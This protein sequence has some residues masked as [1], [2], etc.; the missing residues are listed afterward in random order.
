MHWRR[1]LCQLSCFYVVHQI[2][3]CMWVSARVLRLKLE[4]YT[5]LQL[6]KLGNGVTVEVISMSAHLLQP[7]GIQSWRWLELDQPCSCLCMQS[8]LWTVSSCLAGNPLARLQSITRTVLLTTNI[9][10][11]VKTLQKMLN[12]FW[13]ECRSSASEWTATGVKVLILT[14]VNL[15]INQSIIALMKYDKTHII[16]K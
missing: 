14:R 7:S 9:F 15:I 3:R 4:A 5:L 13:W 10:K 1:Q 16:T 12:Y 11:S 8:H 6:W 2:W